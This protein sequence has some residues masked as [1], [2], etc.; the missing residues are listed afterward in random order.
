MK[1]KYAQATGLDRLSMNVSRVKTLIESLREAMEEACF[2]SDEEIRCENLLDVIDDE[3]S[4]IDRIL[5]S[6]EI[7]NRR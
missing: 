4:T 2:S 7:T 1:N 6:G 5:E 3:M